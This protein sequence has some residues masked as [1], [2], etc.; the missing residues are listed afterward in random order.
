MLASPPTDLWFLEV[1]RRQPKLED[2][3]DASLLAPERELDAIELRAAVARA[4]L[5]DSIPAVMATLRADPAMA[6]R[7]PAA[8]KLLAGQPLPSQRAGQL[9]LLHGGAPALRLIEGAI[10]TAGFVLSFQRMDPELVST[11]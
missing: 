7:D 3:L 9:V 1:P 2:V 10:A 4:V 6:V 8:A 5:G 11:Q